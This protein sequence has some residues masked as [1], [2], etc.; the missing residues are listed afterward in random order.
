MIIMYNVCNIYVF[1]IQRLI[2]C[3][4][5]PPQIETLVC[6]NYSMQWSLY[7]LYPVNA[8]NYR[9]FIWEDNI[10]IAEVHCTYT[11]QLPY[12]YINDID[13]VRSLF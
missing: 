4:V 5:E 13:V 3:V 1:T 6:S 11:L 2:L 12:K 9:K 7:K 10:L 8:E